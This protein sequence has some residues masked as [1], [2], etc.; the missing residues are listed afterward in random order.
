[1]NL[2]KTANVS[3][4]SIVLNAKNI[5]ATGEK[6]ISK[7]DLTR[8]ENLKALS[9][10][11]AGDITKN[12]DASGALVSLTVRQKT[13]LTVQTAKDG[14][15]SANSTGHV[16]LA[17]T[18]GET[19]RIKGGIN[20][21]A[22]EVK[23]LAGNGIT[24][25]GRITAK[26]LTLYG[27]KGDIG[28]KG[29]EIE[30]DLSGTL[31]ANTEASVYLKQT[32]TQVLTLGAIAAGKDINLHA[33]GA[34]RMEAPLGAAPSYLS[35]GNRIRLAAGGSI[36]ANGAA[37]RIL[38]NGAPVDAEAASEISLKG[39]KN[40]DLVL[41]TIRTR[42][43][44][45]TVNVTHGGGTI[46]LGKGGDA[47]SFA[48]VRADKIN[49][50]AKT[51]DL[52]DGSLEGKTVVVEAADTITQQ[53]T[54][55]SAVHASENATFTVGTTGKSGGSIQILSEKNTFSKA[56]VRAADEAAGLMGNVNLVT[57]AASGLTVNFGAG[58]AG[59][60]K[61]KGIDQNR[62][63][64]RV[65]NLAKNQSLTL[66]GKLQT[67]DT[68]M[69]FT[70]GGNLTV[71][72]GAVYTSAR[73]MA[74]AA[75]EDVTIENGAVLDAEKSLL[76]EAGRNILAEGTLKVKGGILATA[77]EGNVH[78]HQTEAQN[79]NIIARAENGSIHMDEALTHEGGIAAE[80]KR[81]DITVGK[82]KAEKGS[83]EL[84]ATNGTLTAD[85][86]QA[87]GSI[88]A[89]G[90]NVVMKQQAAAEKDLTLTATNKLTTEA[91]LSATQNMTLTGSDVTTKK[92]VTA[93]NNL[94]M[95]AQNK[96]TT[97]DELSAEQNMTLTGGDVTTQKKVKAEKDLTLTAT[98]NLTTAEQLTAGGN[99]AASSANGNID[100]TA[101]EAKGGIDLKAT[102]GT[103]TAGVLQ[104][105]GSIAATGKD[106]AMKQKA[107]AEKDL[108]LTA[109]NKLTAEDELSAGAN[110]T[111]TG[112]DVTTQKTVTAGNNLT[113]TAA[114]NLT[115]KETLKAGGWLR[116]LQT[117]GSGN[118]TLRDIKAGSFQALHRGKG[119]IRADNVYAQHYGFVHHAGVGDI[120]L[121]TMQVGNT[122]RVRHTGWGDI[123][124][125]QL[126]AGQA[127]HFLNRHGGMELGVIDGG[128]RLTILDLSRQAKVRA[129][130]LRASELITIFSLHQE[131]DHFETPTILDLL[132]AGDRTRRA[133]GWLGAAE[134][135]SLFETYWR[136]YDSPDAGPFIDL[137]PWESAFVQ[138]V[139][140]KGAEE[141]IIG[142]DA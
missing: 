91:E 88:T 126:T 64:V 59:T 115:A 58:S 41:G 79:G 65:R 95:T 138:M 100:I 87:K 39:E 13:P 109:T 22:N 106:I 86:L 7:A 27:G 5:G 77:K 136:R 54:E 113:L 68:G 2:Q 94:T 127:A 89:E 66:E 73:N 34:I 51:A 98:N 4:R 78:L 20:A 135:G 47:P 112:G 72:S 96:L 82:A 50:R 122:A 43:A 114:N 81:G 108:T 63:D 48:D 49:L 116:A 12:Y 104:A 101:A 28:R 57:N 45:G 3:G 134:V 93:G 92:K 25:E 52:T 123:F 1:M 33:A 107:A 53:N 137:R 130:V 21:G 121:D 132:L 61:V 142:E 62:L 10:A 125:R 56:N 67:V 99:I 29:A 75:Q 36:G 16:Y 18:E 31:R 141:I 140:E 11:R 15:V 42:D 117:G 46:K 83:I 85:V 119:D 40:G 30:T 9:E 23:L 120:H 74:L 6:T 38:S 133:V 103:L 76:L 131:I 44:N 26:D 60:L 90:K 35:A 8:P 129:N 19:L 105:K 111:L 84:K 17:S 124:T 139:Q 14:G 128:R 80:A 24:A 55:K 110:M 69:A 97:A 70:S 71:K 102:N 37:V 118:I 32:G